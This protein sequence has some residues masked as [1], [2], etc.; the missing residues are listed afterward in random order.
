MTGINLVLTALFLLV[1]ILTVSLVSK[2]NRWKALLAVSFIFYYLLI[3]SKIWLVLLLSGITFLSGKFIHTKRFSFWL[4]LVLLLIPFTIFKFTADGHHFENFRIQSLDSFDAENWQSIFQILGLSYFTFNSISYLMD[5]KR[6]YLPPEKNFFFL[7]LYLIYFPAIFSGP[8]HRAKYLF[9]QFKNI[10]VSNDSITRGSRLILWAM[11]KNIIIAQRLF[12][13]IVQL[14]QSE[15][16][17]PYYLLI[18]VLFF[19]YLYCNFSSFIDFFQ[20]VSQMLNIRLKNNFGN[21]VYLSSSR[22]EFWKS[23]HIT[24]NEWFRDYFFFVISRYDKKRKYTDI[25]LLITFLMI[26]LWHE[27]SMAILLWGTLNGFWIVIE[28][29]IP[30]KKWPQNGIRK[31]TGTI[32][33]LAVSSILAVVF[34]SPNLKGLFDKLFNHAA[35]LPRNFI[36]DYFV[37]IMILLVCLAIMDFHYAKAKNNRFDDYI[38]SKPKVARWFIYFKLTILILVFGMSAGVENYYIQF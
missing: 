7:L 29:K 10:E 15:I 30:F 25:F 11:F 3:G 13:L 34:I 33:H 16:S 19:I 26:A 32:Y 6:K 35:Q 2:A 9:E 4:P 12:V 21:R 17:G 5:V 24:L 31:F 23:W 38:G 14:Q 18:G 8:L 22:Q 37:K 27:V 28:K 36:G 1:S 20:G